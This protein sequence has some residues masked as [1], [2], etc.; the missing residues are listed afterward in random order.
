MDSHNVSP[1]W[2][3]GHMGIEGNDLADALAA[4]P[5]RE[6][7]LGW[8][9]LT[10]LTSAP[11]R[12]STQPVVFSPWLEATSTSS[13]NPGGMGSQHAY[14]LGTTAGALLGTK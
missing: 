8:S 1:H 6:L 4:W 7:S 5:S 2:S 9:C 13:G 11:L 12:P 14:L 3:P 10:V